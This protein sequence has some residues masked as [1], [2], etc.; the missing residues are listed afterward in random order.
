ML[1]ARTSD[2]KGPYSLTRCG[3]ALGCP[4]A[5]LTR[6]VFQDMYIVKLHK[7]PNMLFAR[8][9]IRNEIIIFFPGLWIPDEREGYKV[10]NSEV[11]LFFEHVT[12]VALN[13]LMPG[14][15]GSNLPPDFDAELWRSRHEN[16]SMEFSGRVLSSDVAEQLGDAL[17]EAL[18]EACTRGIALDWARGFFFL[19]QIKGVKD[20]N[21][22]DLVDAA[23][24]FEHFLAINHLS[25]EMIEKSPDEW[26]FDL[27]A[28][29]SSASGKDSMAWTAGCHAAV[30][31]DAARIPEKHAVRMTQLGSTSYYK[32]PTSHLTEVA[33]CRVTPGVLGRGPLEVVK[34]Q[35]YQT[36]KTLTAS[37]GEG[38]GIHAKHITLKQLLDKK[39]P[40]VFLE[41]LFD[42]CQKAR[43]AG[44]VS[45][46]RFEI[47]V[48][49]PNLE[50]AYA[51]LKALNW[52]KYLVVIPCD[53][54]WW[55]QHLRLSRNAA[56]ILPF[57][58][59]F[60]DLF[61]LSRTKP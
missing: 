35:L 9:G 22:H 1:C 19:H 48:P 55:V 58:S 60:F 29:A 40:S 47:R 41:K 34:M 21:P 49:Y 2:L 25:R 15:R 61:H 37:Q 52:R 12:R 57:T 5:K 54:W 28:E 32:D 8:W 6:L 43:D 13:R 3:G 53:D 4:R 51:A 39:N 44:V 38:P 20:S 36:D 10:D 46:G 56:E 30:L 50:A 16:G 27:G 14:L 42:V 45:N 31:R 7:I 26:A 11:A 33:G 59:G 24:A 17:R 23:A 18:E